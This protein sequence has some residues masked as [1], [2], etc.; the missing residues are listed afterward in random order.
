M[1]FLWDGAVTA[2][3]CEGGYFEGGKVAAVC[4]IAINDK[5]SDFKDGIDFFYRYEED[6]DLF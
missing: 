2:H 1:I 4:D 3:Q 6:F 5:F